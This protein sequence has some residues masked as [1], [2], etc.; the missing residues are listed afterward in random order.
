LGALAKSAGNKELIYLGELITWLQ[1]FAAESLIGAFRKF[2]V[3]SLSRLVVYLSGQLPG[4]CFERLFDALSFEVK[5]EL[6][7]SVPSSLV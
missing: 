6:L 1:G 2:D 3:V 4:A 7:G 5:L